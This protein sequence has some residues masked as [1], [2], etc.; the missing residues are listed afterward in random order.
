MLTIEYKCVIILLL[1][2]KIE[3]RIKM[4][5]D[6][7]NKLKNLA[8]IFFIVGAVGSVVSGIILLTKSAVILGIIVAVV[9]ALL[10]YFGGL[11]AYALGICAEAHEYPQAAR[12]NKGANVSTNLQCVKCGKFDSS[13]KYYTVQTALGKINRPYC[14]ECKTEYDKENANT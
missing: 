1:P 13:V 11:A 10:S 8:I 2:Q 9:G 4:F 7:G 5:E 6:V 14:S 3:R 12:K